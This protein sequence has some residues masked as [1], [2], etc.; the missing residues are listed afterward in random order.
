[1]VVAAIVQ[2]IKIRMRRGRE[3]LGETAACRRTPTRS[4]VLARR[5][6]ER[7]RV[8]VGIAVM[9]AHDLVLRRLCSGPGTLL[10]K[11]R[12]YNKHTVSVVVAC[13]QVF[14]VFL[15]AD[16]QAF[17]FQV[18]VHV[19]VQLQVDVAKQRDAR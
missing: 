14:F 4:V 10:S 6:D 12:Y 9:R 18:Q 7:M 17:C 5:R 11:C 3:S 16:S 8:C 15:P 1:M 2:S 19:H 13:L